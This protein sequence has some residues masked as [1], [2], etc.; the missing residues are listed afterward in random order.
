MPLEE[1]AQ[2]IELKL[3]SENKD[4]YKLTARIIDNITLSGDNREISTF[5]K[6]RSMN[7]ITTNYDRLF[8]SLNEE[9]LAMTQGRPIPQQHKAIRI[10]HIHGSTDEP[11]DMVIT[12]QDYYRFL[13]HDT[14]FPHKL[15]TLL[16]ESTIDAYHGALGL[17]KD[18]TE[19]N[20][21]QKTSE[22]KDPKK[23][24]EKDR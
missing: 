16:Y 23:R 20:P 1:C 10:Y 8:E 3:I 11:P 21:S 15:M 19:P 4:I 18:G 5:L 6:G 9:S 12:A 22:P 13:N 14:Y 7:V 24:P 17:K 2:L